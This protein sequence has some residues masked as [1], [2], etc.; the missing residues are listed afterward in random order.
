MGVY[1]QLGVSANVDRRKRMF[2]WVSKQKQQQQQRQSKRQMCHK[3]S[4]TWG[5]TRKDLGNKLA[6][7]HVAA[8]S[9][10]AEHSNLLCRSVSV[11]VS[12]YQ[13]ELLHVAADRITVTI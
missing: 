8:W 4:H 1:A 13:T 12:N 7:L 2:V 11:L 5:Y 3:H 6:A 9:P 10:A